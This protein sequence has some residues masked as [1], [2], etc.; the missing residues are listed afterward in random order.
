MDIATLIGITVGLAGLLAGFLI[1]GGHIGQLI[2]IS[3]FLI[4]IVGTLGATMASFSFRELA[5]LPAALKTLVAHK[6]PDEPT[7]VQQIVH[8]AETA[9]REGLL[10]LE[11]KLEEVD[12]PF[13]RKGLQLIVDGA[14]PEV[15][16]SVLQTEI[17]AIQERHRIAHDIFEYAGG[18]SPTMGIIGTVMGLIHVLANIST[19]DKLGPAIALAFTATLY[20]VSAANVIYFPIGFRLK[21]IT[22]KEINIRLLMMEGLLALQA[23]HNPIII[24]EQLTAFLSPVQQAKQKAAQEEGTRGEGLATP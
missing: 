5:T 19:P 24:M 13:L 6:I 4:V 22:R 9:R 21:N 15:V 16:K 10:S 20:G 12:D 8:Y 14:D 1:E 18:F 11:K 7:V 2:S 17:F 23:G 3:G